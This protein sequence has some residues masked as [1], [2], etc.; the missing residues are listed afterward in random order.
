[1]VETYLEGV[2]VIIQGNV[3]TSYFGEIQLHSFDKLDFLTL[4]HEVHKSAHTEIKNHTSRCHFLWD[5][6]QTGAS[7]V[8]VEILQPS[9]YLHDLHYRHHISQR[10]L[11][12]DDERFVLEEFLLQQVE[13]LIQILDSSVHLLLRHLEAHDWKKHSLHR[14]TCENKYSFSRSSVNKCYSPLLLALYRVMH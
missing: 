8:T 11:V 6:D 10:D 9:Y 5:Q 4:L 13:R 12:P 3:G 7:P 14:E 1:M 2:N